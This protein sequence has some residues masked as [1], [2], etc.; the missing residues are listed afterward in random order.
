M[1]TIKLNGKG[2]TPSA[3]TRMIGQATK[4]SDRYNELV[5][6]I[7]SSALAHAGLHSNLSPLIEFMDTLKTKRGALSKQ[8]RTIRDYILHHYKVIEITDAGINFKKVKVKVEGGDAKETKLQTVDAAK[9]GNYYTGVRLENG[10][11]E[12]KRFD[13]DYKGI[14]PFGEWLTTDY[15]T[16]DKSKA[17]S[18]VVTPNQIRRRL[19]S[20]TR[21]VDGK[22]YKGTADDWAKLLKEVSELSTALLQMT[23]TTDIDSENA[24]LNPPAMGVPGGTPNTPNDGKKNV[25]VHASARGK[26]ASKAA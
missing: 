9:R 11:P 26:V 19:E 10:R 4:S 5:S 1:A 2:V 20:I 21:M 17:D 23:P 12:V 22:Q 24:A 6:S 3:I 25:K 13:S 16:E 8:G 15:A 14:T 18:N 7:V